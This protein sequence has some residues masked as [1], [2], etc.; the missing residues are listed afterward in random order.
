MNKHLTIVIGVLLFA[1]SAHSQTNT[2]T[3]DEDTL[4]NSMVSYISY[5]PTIADAKKLIEAP[6]VIDSSVPKPSVRYMYANEQ[7]GTKY[8]PDTIKAARM[9]GEPLDPLYRGYA[10]VGAGN[11]INYLA[12]IYLNALRSR[13]GSVGFKLNGHGTQGN[14]TSLPHPAPFSHWNG[15]VFGKKFLKKHAIDASVGY[16]RERVMY[17]GFDETNPFYFDLPQETAF[18]QVYNDWSADVSLKSF[19][20]D[21]SKLN[22][23][24][25]L[26]Y[27]YFSDLYMANNE[28]NVVAKANMN[29]FFGDHMFDLDIVAD[30]NAIN[31]ANQF[32]FQPFDTITKTNTNFIANIYPKFISQANKFRVEVG[33]QLQAELGDDGTTPYIYPSVNAKYNL[34]KEIIIPYASLN[35]G[36]GRKLERNNLNSLTGQNPFLWTSLTPLQNSKEIYNV[37]G[38][39]RGAFTSRF[40]YNLFAAKYKQE[41]MPLFTNYDASQFNPGAS[42][43]GENFFTVVYDTVAVT[44]I[45]GELTYRIDE[46]LQLLASGVYRAYQATHE[47]EA[48]QMPNFEAHIS[49]VYELRKKIYLKGELHFFGPRWSKSYNANDEFLGFQGQNVYGKS[50]S[51]LVDVTLG[52]EYRYTERLSAFINFNNLVAQ[53]YQYWNQYPVQRF[54]VMFGASFSFWKE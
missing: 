7:Y 1:Y 27:H 47:F 34:V 31:Y 52:A 2:R 39:F 16:D 24:I 22:H 9:K 4:K 46:R 41:N 8:T 20:T 54:N 43:F 18:K 14:I 50:L 36:F 37:K 29:T 28:H 17:Y 51:S 40:T 48:W 10:K 11:G 53:Q 30:L 12:D 38:G 25:D 6:S 26:G 49:G 5:R 19:Y 45:G 44:E 33:V 13:D 35:G 15:K 21:S 3:G 23:K 32:V 42:R